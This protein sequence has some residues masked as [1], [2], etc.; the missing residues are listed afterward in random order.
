[1]SVRRA[2][3]AGSLAVSL[4][5]GIGAVA[6]GDVVTSA[7][8]RV[9]S[10]RA[11][12]AYGGP[13][14]R[15][16]RARKV[17]P[18]T[19]APDAQPVTPPST[20]WI[21]V[22]AACDR[23]PTYVHIA[24]PDCRPGCGGHRS[25][26]EFWAHAPPSPGCT[27]GTLANPNDYLDCPGKDDGI[28]CSYL[29]LSPGP[30]AATPVADVAVFIGFSNNP[31]QNASAPLEPE[32]QG[33]GPAD[34]PSNT[35]PP[36]TFGTLQVGQMIGCTEGSWSGSLPGGLPMAFSFRYTRD[37]TPLTPFSK[38]GRS[39]TIQQADAGHTLFC[40]VRA[41]NAE[42]DH[43]IATSPPDPV[44]VQSTTSPPGGTGP[45]PST[46]VTPATPPSNLFDFFRFTPSP[47]NGTGLLILDLP[48]AG[49]VIVA[50]DA[51]PTASHARAAA[52]RKSLIKRVTVTAKAKG[53]LKLRIKP[54][55]AG[56][57][58]LRRTGSLKVR[59]RVSYKPT[60]GTA[61]TR[62]TTIRLRLKKR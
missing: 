21:Q 37:G 38:D 46:P 32:A 39:Y 58:K 16:V 1:M 2:V 14:C 50:D 62:R 19:R 27:T 57:A 10:P 25:I 13:P 45:A 41:K 18:A 23:K 54:T 20:D 52:K 29:R 28:T 31:Q 47:A 24:I 40:Q 26:V 33:C 44:P 35:S 15:N 56:M 4:A 7:G 3:Q 34:H 8:T 55:A 22:S 6:G 9:A 60:G 48:G 30:A 43:T 49:I 12:V 11:D 17:R 61:N 36:Q 59:L 5:I 42:G 51:A 53:R